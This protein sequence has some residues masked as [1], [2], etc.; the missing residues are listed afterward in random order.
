MRPGEMTTT[1]R[2]QHRKNTIIE[3]EYLRPVILKSLF[4]VV[5]VV[6]RWNNAS[7]DDF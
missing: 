3:E 1:T 2:S 5:R 7:I 4:E 6:W